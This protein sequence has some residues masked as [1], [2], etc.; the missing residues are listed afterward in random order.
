MIHLI[1]ISSLNNTSFFSSYHLIWEKTK[2]E[3]MILIKNIDHTKIDSDIF[4]KNWETTLLILAKP[5]IF[6]HF[7]IPNPQNGIYKTQPFFWENHESQCW[8]KLRHFHLFFFLTSSFSKRFPQM[9]AYCLVFLLCVLGGATQENRFDIIQSIFAQN[10][11]YT[12]K[13]DGQNDIGFVA[14]KS[15]IYQVQLPTDLE[16]PTE[17]KYESVVRK[18][19]EG[20]KFPIF[21]FFFFKFEWKIFFCLQDTCYFVTLFFI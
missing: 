3:K 8:A 7:S 18:N 13:V 4:Y 17:L 5:S 21:L 11:L 1:V 2:K 12:V 6:Q 19:K 15:G 20:C 10:E 16:G 9:K 14:Y